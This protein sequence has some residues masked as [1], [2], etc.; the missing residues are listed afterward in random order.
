M[1]DNALQSAKKKSAFLDEGEANPNAWCG[2]LH[3]EGLRRKVYDVTQMLLLMWTLY[4][5]PIRIAFAIQPTT[6]EATFWID[7]GVDSFFMLD[8]FVQM[9]TYYLSGRS[10]QWVSNFRKIRRRYFRSWFIVDFVAVF[11]TDYIIRLL[12]WHQGAEVRLIEHNTHHKDLKLK[13]SPEP[14]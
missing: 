5:V 7:V 11:P 12:Q 8:L 9:H 10:G 14:A 3:P 13:I 1:S 2:L 4:T 6:A